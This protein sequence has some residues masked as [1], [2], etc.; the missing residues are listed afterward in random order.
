MRGCIPVF[1]FIKC[2]HKTIFTPDLITK[3]V[4]KMLE[5]FH[6][7]LGCIRKCGKSG[8]GCNGAFIVG[9]RKCIV[10]IVCI[11]CCEPPAV[12]PVT[13][14]FFW[15]IHAVIVIDECMISVLFPI[16][17]ITVLQAAWI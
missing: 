12:L 6:G 3:V 2:I 9:G 16:I 11:A 14:K 17:C 4:I 13:F 7:I 8:G 10:T 15:I 5:C 1:C